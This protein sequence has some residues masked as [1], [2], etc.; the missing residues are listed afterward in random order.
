[1]N[2][3]SFEGKFAFENPASLTQFDGWSYFHN[4]EKY[5]TPYLHTVPKG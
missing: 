4:V 3:V 2:V 1:M 5:K